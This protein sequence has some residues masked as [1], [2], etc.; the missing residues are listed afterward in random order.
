MPLLHQASQICR[1]DRILGKRR[2]PDLLLT[3]FISLKLGY[4]AWRAEGPN[5]EYVFLLLLGQSN[6]FVRLQALAY[7]LGVCN[8]CA[9]CVQWLAP[10]PWKLRCSPAAVRT[11]EEMGL[12]LH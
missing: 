9:I 6:T 4:G 1:F 2:K 3:L 5:A 12:L 11:C 8:V 10:G 7:S